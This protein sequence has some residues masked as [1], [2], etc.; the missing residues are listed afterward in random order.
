[1][2][3]GNVRLADSATPENFA[4]RH[5]NYACSGNVS[6]VEHVLHRF[7]QFLE[8]LRMRLIVFLLRGALCRK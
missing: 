5:E 8:R 6:F 2:L 7:L 4:I 1:M 3:R